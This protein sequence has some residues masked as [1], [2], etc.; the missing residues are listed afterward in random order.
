MPTRFINLFTRKGDP[1][2]DPFAGIGTNAIAATLLERR[3]LG[4]E[5]V[6]EYARTAR[7][8]IRQAKSLFKKNTGK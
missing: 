6:A 1:V 7:K 3:Y 2:F 8:R 4:I 5:I